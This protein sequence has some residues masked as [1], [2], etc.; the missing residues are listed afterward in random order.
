VTGAARG[1]GRAYAIALAEAGIDVVAADVADAAETARAVESHGVRG[2]AVRCDISSE[3]DVAALAEQTEA[4][5]GGCDILVNNAGFVARAGLE[6]LTLEEW[7]QT[8]RVNLDGM[9]L[10]CRRFVPGMRER[11]WG[12]VINVTSTTVG[13]VMNG[14]LAYVTSKAG[15]IGFT[16]ALA[17]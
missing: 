2:L 14:F 1:L 3:D 8:M 10:T 12:R 17:S 4:E 7:H 13:L 5:L 6:D 16:R 9:L 15:I 11:S